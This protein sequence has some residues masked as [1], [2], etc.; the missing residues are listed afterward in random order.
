MTLRNDF[1]FPNVYILLLEM[2]DL[3]LNGGCGMIRC[4]FILMRIN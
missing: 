4:G 2:M 3:L 1:N